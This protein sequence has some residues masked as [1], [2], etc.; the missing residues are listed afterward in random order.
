MIFLN[1]AIMCQFRPKVIYALCVLMGYFVATLLNQRIHHIKAERAG[2]SDS[3]VDSNQRINPM[4]F[5]TLS[6][7]HLP[8]AIDWKFIQI[9]SDSSP[10]KKVTP[11]EHPAMYYGL[12]LL[13]ELDPA[14]YE[15]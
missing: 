4:L 3:P 1:K 2:W 5:K 11:P 9:L 13:S 15:V 8:V 10:M 7:G 12:D 14:F 6:F